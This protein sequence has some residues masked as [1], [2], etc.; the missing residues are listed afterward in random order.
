MRLIDGADNFEGRVEVC[1]NGKWGT[2]CD[3]SWDIEDATATC[4]QLGL[5]TDSMLFIINVLCYYD[6]AYQRNR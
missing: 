6:D 4:R 1:V 5:P 3:Q 2:V